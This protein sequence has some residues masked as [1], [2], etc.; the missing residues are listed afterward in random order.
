M[1]NIYDAN[2]DDFRDD[3]VG[4]GALKLKSIL[5]LEKLDDLCTD[6]GNYTLDREIKNR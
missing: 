4:T 2:T 3:S 1:Q 6:F 5:L